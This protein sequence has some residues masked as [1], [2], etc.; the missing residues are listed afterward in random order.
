MLFSIVGA[1]MAVGAGLVAGLGALFTAV[2]S[3]LGLGPAAPYEL[4]FALLGGAAAALGAA[5]AAHWR[6]VPPPGLG[7]APSPNERTALL[8]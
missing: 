4:N 5:L 3:A 1:G 7:A 2:A 8:N 6:E